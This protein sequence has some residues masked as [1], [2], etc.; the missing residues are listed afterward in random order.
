MAAGAIVYYHRRH[1]CQHRLHQHPSPCIA[2]RGE[3]ESVGGL[4]QVAYLVF[5]NPAKKLDAVTKAKARHFSFQCGALGP[6]SDD[7]KL[8][9][10]QGW[11]GGKRGY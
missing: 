10:L 3:D 9:F 7:Q 5:G 6:V 1:P 4:H 11:T 8:V 2:D